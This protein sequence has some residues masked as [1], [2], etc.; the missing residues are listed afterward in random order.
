MQ[1]KMYFC[2]ASEVSP[3]VVNEGQ[4]HLVHV[5][6]LMRQ[7]GSG[8]TLVVLALCPVALFVILGHRPQ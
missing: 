4:R 3:F 1:C 6:T 5:G 2:R 8:P 7:E